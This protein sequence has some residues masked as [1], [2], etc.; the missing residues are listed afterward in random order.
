MKFVNPFIFPAPYPRYEE[1]SFKN[2]LCYIPWNDHIF[3][4]PCD[5]PDFPDGIPCL[6]FPAHESASILLFL[7]GNAEDL[8][9]IF[10]FLRH[11]RNQ[12]KVNTLALEYPGYGLL[13]KAQPSVESVNKVATTVL[14]HLVDRIGVSYS[15][16]FLL[17]RSIGSG[18]A[19]DLSSRYPLGGLVLVSAFTSLREAVAAVVGRLPAMLVSGS[20]FPNGSLIANVSCPTLFIH[21]RG[22]ALIPSSH[23]E[24]LHRRCRAK[25]MIVLPEGMEHNSNLFADADFLAV[26]VINFF[27]FPGFSS[28][29]PPRLPRVLFL[30]PHER[31]KRKR[32]LER[33]VKGRSRGGRQGSPQGQRNG[34]VMEVDG[35]SD[36]DWGMCAF[37]P[38]GPSRSQTR[39]SLRGG[40]ERTWTGP[41]RPLHAGDVGEIPQP[42]PVSTPSLPPPQRVRKPPSLSQSNGDSSISG[43][44]P[45][46]EVLSARRFFEAPPPADP[47]QKGANKSSSSSSSANLHPNGGAAVTSVDS[48]GRL[49]PHSAAAPGGAHAPGGG[50][51]RDHKKKHEQTAGQGAPSKESMQRTDF[52]E[53]VADAAG[54]AVLEEALVRTPDAVVVSASRKFAL[55]APSSPGAPSPPNS[56]DKSDISFEV[57]LRNREGVMGANRTHPGRSNNAQGRTTA[58]TASG[59]VHTGGQGGRGSLPPHASSFP[60]QSVSGPSLHFGAFRRNQSERMAA[61]GE[62]DGPISKQ[63]PPPR[64]C[65]PSSVSSASACSLG[66]LLSDEFLRGETPRSSVS[67][68]PSPSQSGRNSPTTRAGPSRSGSWTGP[69]SSEFDPHSSSNKMGGKSGNGNGNRNQQQASSRAGGRG[70]RGGGGPGGGGGWRSLFG[71]R[72]HNAVES[73]A[74][75][76]GGEDDPMHGG[77]K[78]F[79]R[80]SADR[81]LNTIDWEAV[82]LAAMND[83]VLR[84]A[85]E[86]ERETSVAAALAA[87]EEEGDSSSSAIPSR[88]RDRTGSSSLGGRLSP[89][90]RDKPASHPRGRVG[91]HTPSAE[92]TSGAGRQQWRNSSAQS[93][94]EVNL[95]SSSHQTAA[96]QKKP[97]HMQRQPPHPHS[98]QNLPVAAPPRPQAPP[99]PGSFDR[100]LSAS[101]SGSSQDESGQ[102]SAASVLAAAAAAG[103]GRTSDPISLQEAKGRGREGKEAKGGSTSGVHGAGRGQGLNFLRRRE[104]PSQS[105]SKKGVGE[106]TQ[107]QQQ[108]QQQGRVAPKEKVSASGPGRPPN[109]HLPQQGKGQQQQQQGGGRGKASTSSRIGLAG[110][111][112]GVAE[113]KKGNGERKGVSGHPAER[114]TNAAVS[115]SVPSVVSFDTAAA[116]SSLSPKMNLSAGPEGGFDALFS[117]PSPEHQQ[118]SNRAQ[119][120]PPV[121]PPLPLHQLKSANSAAAGRAGVAPAGGV[122]PKP[123][124]EK[125]K[126]TRPPLARSAPGA[127]PPGASSSSSHAPHAVGSGAPNTLHP[128]QKK[129]QQQLKASKG[130]SHQ[131]GVPTVHGGGRGER[132][133][134]ER[135]RGG[136][137]VGD[138]TACAFA[139]GELDSSSAGSGVGDRPGGGLNQMLMQKQKNELVNASTKGPLSVAPGML[140]RQQLAQSKSGHSLGA[141]GGGG[142]RQQMSLSSSQT[143]GGFQ[144]RGRATPSPSLPARRERESATAASN[145]SVIGRAAEGTKGNNIGGGGGWGPDIHVRLRGVGGTGA[146]RGS[147]R[148][149]P[150][151]SRPGDGL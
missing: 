71:K 5:D 69:E 25:K 116:S 135:E 85:L 89:F 68:S 136:A 45:A 59:G 150:G 118:T 12:F 52:E 70:G 72:H 141:G 39:A 99:K 2:T 106:A 80:S 78:G 17:G 22:D 94:A 24:E 9:M 96:K 120:R 33:R 1:G 88:G 119:Q 146:L 133:E 134:R 90:C 86:R 57:R 13:R 114:P 21:G 79:G 75:E 139:R 3:P 19:V 129:Q 81:L 132:G 115:P 62:G 32:I 140:F 74:G 46:L 113:A 14:R 127:G 66:D 138:L 54:A 7:H 73:G 108:Q 103:R 111:G 137:S 15:Q 147:G 101:N 23:S 151:P 47:N 44:E 35:E 48:L 53:A 109:L 144:Q 40:S 60:S 142:A 131:P 27:G 43:G 4:Q 50:F 124:N 117:S 92:G 84:D 26:P 38:S 87:G 83:P 104:E 18:P 28:A 30:S 61:A 6:F 31:K 128:A 64:A 49:F 93:P 149:T 16:V 10:S 95:S 29:N 41:S 110:G 36:T 91:A 11:M 97:T 76:T 130:S 102:S 123:P 105:S 55:A 8:G 148:G 145:R 107:Q 34:D 121:V 125:E 58:A 37:S 126:Q 112:A 122:Q 51:K 77:T 67:L 42:C 65:S 98:Q 143:A 82:C 56:V 20:A 100:S 63:A